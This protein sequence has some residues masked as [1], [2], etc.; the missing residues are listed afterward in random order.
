M[1][2]C[3]LPV[4]TSAY[5]LDH[6]AL[7]AQKSFLV[8]VDD[9]HERNL[10]QVKPFAQQI[11]AHEHVK[12]AETQIAQDLH[13]LQRLDLR[14]QIARCDACVHQIICEILRHALGQRCHEHTLVAHNAPTHAI[15]EIVDL[16]GDRMDLDGRIQKPRWADDLLHNLLAVLEFIIAWRC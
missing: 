11:D 7:T 14:M 3:M 16:P 4:I 15:D 13:T 2:R 1:V 5:G 10:R 12:F 9:R 6:R 8:G